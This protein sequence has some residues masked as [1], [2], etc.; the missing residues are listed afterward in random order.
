MAI[1][2]LEG[3]LFTQK[4]GGAPCNNLYSMYPSPSPL[5]LIYDLQAHPMVELAAK[6]QIIYFVI[7][8]V[9]IPI[10]NIHA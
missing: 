5:N 10:D 9:R 8:D 2:Y 7:S 6:H 1:K 3:F 4:F